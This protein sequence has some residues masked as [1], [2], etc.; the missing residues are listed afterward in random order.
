MPIQGATRRQ[1]EEAE[2]TTADVSP[3]RP[4]IVVVD[5]P[6]LRERTLAWFRS[7]GVSAKGVTTPEAALAEARVE[8]PAL[9]LLD[10][11]V[12]GMDGWELLRELRADPELAATPVV[13]A[14]MSALDGADVVVDGYVLAPFTPAGADDLM[15]TIL[16]QPTIQRVA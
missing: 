10:T 8:P 6:A 5:D 4:T 11:L 1:R 15:R 3:T 12:A 16:A 7:M 13:I 14:S 2:M 9:V